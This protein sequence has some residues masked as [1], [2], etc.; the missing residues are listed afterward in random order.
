MEKLQVEYR[1]TLE[2]LNE[3]GDGKR[4]KDA[5]LVLDESFKPTNAYRDKRYLRVD[6]VSADKD[7]SYRPYDCRFKI[8][9]RIDVTDGRPTDP[10]SE[11]EDLADI[12][13]KA[14]KHPK[15][16]LRIKD[17]EVCGV[18]S[19]FRPRI[20]YVRKMHTQVYRLAANQQGA[21]TDTFLD[22]MAIRINYGTEYT[23]PSASGVFQD[24]DRDRVEVTAIPELPDLRD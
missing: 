6:V 16:L 21:T 24:I 11:S 5:T 2:K 20:T 17:G 13:D 8:T 9:S 10:S 12:L 15:T 19:Y 22:G 23:R 14:K 1:L 4:R 7:S 3:A 18:D